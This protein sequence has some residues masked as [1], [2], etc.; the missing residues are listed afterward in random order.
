LIWLMFSGNAGFRCIKG[1]PV[2][3][4]PGGD[5]SFSRCEATP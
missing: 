3:G 2:H 1:K 5:A 4:V